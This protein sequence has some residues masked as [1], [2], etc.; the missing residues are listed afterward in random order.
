MGPSRRLCAMFEAS[1]CRVLGF[2]RSCFLAKMKFFVLGEEEQTHK[3]PRS[4][5]FHNYMVRS[6]E[7][8]FYEIVGITYATHLALVSL[9]QFYLKLTLGNRY[10]AGRFGPMP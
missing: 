5:N 6:M 8:E 4:Y 10:A 7:D 3:L 9:L 2:F 1:L